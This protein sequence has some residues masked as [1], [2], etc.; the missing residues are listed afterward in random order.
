M[1][2]NRGNDPLLANLNAFKNK[3]KSAPVLP[4]KSKTT[5]NNVNGT[6]YG[7]PKKRTASQRNEEEGKQVIEVEELDEDDDDDDGVEELDANDDDDDD[8]DE[9]PMKKVRPGSIAAAALQATQTDISKSHDSSKLLWATEYIQKK[10]KPVLVSELMDYLSM[11]KDD[12]VLELL[13]KLDKIQYDPKKGTFK[14][15]STYDVHSAQ[16]LINLL[17]SQVT[18]KG[19]SCKELKDGWPQCDETVN[20]L[21]D[22][23][24]IL[25]LRT[26]KDKTPRYVWY[27]NGGELNRID[28]D[29]VKMWENVQ[30]PQ[31]AELPRKLQDLGLKPASIDPATIKRQT[32][33]VEAK[34]KRQRKGKITNTHM[35][36]ILKDYSHKA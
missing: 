28:E 32:T 34:K 15:M 9:S 29:F 3:V 6:P 1:I 31:F 19:I 27:N 14:Y 7:S 13:K 26:K 4:V 30:L 23:S 20:E 18:F 36:G 12:K 33:R 11:K 35:A 25:V 5:S 2:M 17:R 21:E 8:D 10:G 16:E 24:K 22:E